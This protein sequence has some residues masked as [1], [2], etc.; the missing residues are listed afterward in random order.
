[1]FLSRQ[2]VELGPWGFFVYTPIGTV[3]ILPVGLRSILMRWEV[4]IGVLG[5][6]NFLTDHPI[7]LIRGMR[8]A[9]GR[10]HTHTKYQVRSSMR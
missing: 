9:L 2:R 6:K 7:D 10:V 5:L 3:G 4:R 1:M 8:V